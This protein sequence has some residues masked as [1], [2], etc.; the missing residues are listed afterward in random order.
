M[1]RLADKFPPPPTVPI[2]VGLVD[3]GPSMEQ[4]LEDREKS[5]KVAASKND[6][7]GKENAGLRAKVDYLQKE[8]DFTAKDRYALI[9]EKFILQNKLED[10]N[11]WPE[12]RVEYD[13]LATQYEVMKRQRAREHISQEQ[14][15]Y[16]AKDAKL[17]L[18]AVKRAEAMNKIAHSEELKMVKQEH[19]KAREKYQTLLTTTTTTA[20]AIATTA[21]AGRDTLG[22]KALQEEN[23]RLTLALHSK[24]S[25]LSKKTSD[26]ERMQSLVKTRSDHS[27]SQLQSAASTILTLKEE[28]A[29]SEERI[30]ELERDVRVAN[31]KAEEM[32]DMYMAVAFADEGEEEEEE[33]RSG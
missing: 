31:E 14:I 6:D 20:T 7:L 8:L 25:L 1:R 24:T 21:A 15:L 4:L 11:S 9:R 19:D 12:F 27:A 18:A 29:K 32:E 2:N 28:K 33:E 17:E 3:V 30:A 23:T 22:D 5:L 16:I 26:L 10:L 13:E